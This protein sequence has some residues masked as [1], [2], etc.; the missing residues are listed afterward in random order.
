MEVTR[1]VGTRAH[2]RE[3]RPGGF[4]IGAFLFVG[5][6]RPVPVRVAL[7]EGL[8]AEQA[9]EACGF[10]AEHEDALAIDDDRSRR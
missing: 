5:W 10:E 2:R 9:R 7:R 6:A 8:A 3:G 1:L 4:A